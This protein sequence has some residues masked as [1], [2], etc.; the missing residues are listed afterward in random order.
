LHLVGDLF[1]GCSVFNYMPVALV[2][3]RAIR[4]RVYGKRHG[5]L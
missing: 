2:I 4:T 5:L 1:E 3:S